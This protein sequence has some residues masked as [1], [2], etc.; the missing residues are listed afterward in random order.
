MKSVLPVAILMLFA[1]PALG[2]DT[3]VQI[4]G[5]V[6]GAIAVHPTEFEE[7]WDPDIAFGGFLAGDWFGPID[8]R[9]EGGQD[10][11]KCAD[12]FCQNTNVE[13][14]I[15]HLG[16][17]IQWPFSHG[18]RAH[19]YGNITVSAYRQEANDRSGSET[20]VGLKAGF[21][22]NIYLGDQWGIGGEVAGKYIFLDRPAFDDP[23]YIVP[24]GHL[25][26]SF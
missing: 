25:F 26:W 11:M 3:P 9:V 24:T 4:G 22:L 1:L 21:G 12:G 20:D 2:H 14:E 15:T 23:L 6:G 10:R 8:W 18:D 7:K 5:F 13:L 19:F 16:G 17:G